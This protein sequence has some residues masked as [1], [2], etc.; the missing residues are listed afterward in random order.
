M[1]FLYTQGKFGPLLGLYQPPERGCLPKIGLW[2]CMQWVHEQPQM[3]VVRVLKTSA[4]LYKHSELLFYATIHIFSDLGRVSNCSSYS[5]VAAGLLCSWRRIGHSQNRNRFSETV[6]RAVVLA[7]RQPFAY[8]CD[9][10][11][12]D[13]DCA[14]GVPDS[15]LF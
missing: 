14:V 13:S 6:A 8:W 2:V 7:P 10:V 12:N 9:L 3:H 5:A 1:R 15:P 4:P 11:L